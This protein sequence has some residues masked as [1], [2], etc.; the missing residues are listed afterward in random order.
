MKLKYKK[1]PNLIKAIANRYKVYNETLD[2]IEEKRKEGKV[3]V[4]QPKSPVN[5]SR[6]EKN[7]D[8]L[9]ALYNEGYDFGD[10]RYL[11]PFLDGNVNE[12]DYVK[13]DESIVLYYF[14]LLSESNDKILA[15]LCD[16]FLNRK[17]FAY[18]DLNNEEE[19][20][21]IIKEFAKSG[22]IGKYIEARELIIALP[23]GLYHY[24]HDYLIKHFATDFKKK[25]GVDCYAA[26]HHNKRKT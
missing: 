2:F 10:I 4:I 11:K 20:I 26:L 21:K 19:K 7:K 22:T 16:R 24:E 6:V 17:L 8:K 18:R 23:E 25:Y 15:D 5:I 12:V 13:L 3:F 1:Y 9:K 14:R